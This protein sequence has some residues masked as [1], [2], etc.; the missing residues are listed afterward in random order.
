MNEDYIVRTI[1]QVNYP[2]SIIKNKLIYKITGGVIF[3]Y[4]ISYSIMSVFLFVFLIPILTSISGSKELIW[5][6]PICVAIELFM[7]LSMFY[8]NAFVITKGE[9]ISQN[10]QKITEVLDAFYADLD[11]QV[12][13]ELIMRSITPVGSP[14]WG[15]IITILFDDNLIYLNITSLGK[16][17]T[18]STAHG[19]LN[20]LKARKIAAYYNLHN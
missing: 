17:N 16:G 4:V 5:A 2:K 11:Y 1:P 7:V 9:D 19:F 15:R 20:Y 18:T 10:K 6:V 12:N 14:I 8:R 3:D 13:D